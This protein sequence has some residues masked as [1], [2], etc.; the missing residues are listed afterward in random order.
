MNKN[1]DQHVRKIRKFYIGTNSAAWVRKKKKK[2]P[3]RAQVSMFSL[4]SQP[5]SSHG[6]SMGSMV[7]SCILQ[8]GSAKIITKQLGIY[9]H[10]SLMVLLKGARQAVSQSD[11]SVRSGQLYMFACGCKQCI[12]ASHKTTRF[13]NRSWQLA[14]LA[15]QTPSSDESWTFWRGR[16]YL[17]PNTNSGKIAS[18]QLHGVI[19]TKFINLYKSTWRN[20]M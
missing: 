8:C 7:N 11:A 17:K 3:E 16:L 19:F 10:H 18:L 12:N 5:P 15:G 6:R 20:L 14:A 4:V 9:S 1:C 13:W 2:K